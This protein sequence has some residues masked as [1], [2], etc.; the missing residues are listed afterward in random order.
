MKKL[1]LITL[2]AASGISLTMHTPLT[3]MEKNEKTEKLSPSNC[4]LQ[5]RLQLPEIVGSLAYS[6]DNQ[7]ILIGSNDCIVRTFDNNK[8]G[9]RLLKLEGHTHFITSVAYSPDGKTVLTGSWDNTARLWCAKTGKQLLLLEG[10]STIV[11]SVAFSPNG[12][13]IITVSQGGSIRFWN[14]ET[15]EVLLVIRPLPTISYI[16]NSL[17][18]S[19][20]KSIPHHIT[21]AAWSPDGET[22]LTGSYDNTARLWSAKTGELL[23]T[24]VG[25]RKVVTC[26]AFSPDGRTLVTGSYDGTTCLWDSKTG[27]LLK[28]LKGHTNN[29]PNEPTDSITSIAINPDGNTILTG[30]TNGTVSLWDRST[31]PNDMFEKRNN[32]TK[33][34]FMRLYPLFHN[35]MQ[36]KST[37][38]NQT[39]TSSLVSLPKDLKHYIMALLLKKTFNYNF[40]LSKTLHIAQSPVNAVAFSPNGNIIIAGS[41]DGK[42]S[43]LKR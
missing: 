5:Y 22:I 35:Y 21:S 3:A 27:R 18:E 8:P 1:F 30:S 10:H 25:H 13:N 40:E 4:V 17:G 34:L 23:A 20:R 19:I 11:S 41:S 15:G 36:D 6:P 32:A 38:S 24:F 14:S 29:P 43:A 33:E 28:I 7:T 16:T 37:N 39:L 26:V 31:C 2:I 9:T 12:K 42:V